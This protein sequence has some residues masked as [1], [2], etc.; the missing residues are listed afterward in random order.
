MRYIANGEGILQHVSF[1]ADISCDENTCQQYLGRVPTGYSSMEDWYQREGDK[2]YRWKAVTNRTTLLM[3]EDADEPAENYCPQ[4]LIQTG[5]AKINFGTTAGTVEVTFPKPYT[6]VPVVFVSQ[7]FDDTNIIL[8]TYKPTTTGF[9]A[10]VGAYFSSSGSR[11]FQ[12]VAIG[13]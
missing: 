13:Q 7:V 10:R 9:T 11:E 12:W 1:G 6:T 5:T 3:I 2:L 4:H 8:Q